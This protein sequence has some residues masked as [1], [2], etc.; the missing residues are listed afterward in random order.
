MLE[1]ACRIVGAEGLAGLTL[2][3]LAVMLG[4]SVTVLTN[5]YGSR[6]DMLLRSSPTA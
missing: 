1:A 3:P 6:A 2:R 5:H 4:V